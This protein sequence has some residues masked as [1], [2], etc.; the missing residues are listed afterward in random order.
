MASKSSGEAGSK[1]TDTA[2]LP[3]ALPVEVSEPSLFTG[4]F[5]E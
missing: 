2:R 5:L 4:E 3:L 1:G